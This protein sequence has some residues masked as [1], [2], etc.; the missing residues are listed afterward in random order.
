M[1]PDGKFVIFLGLVWAAAACQP[2][3]A[4]T[5]TASLPAGRAALPSFPSVTPSIVPSPTPTATPGGRLRL[6]LDFDEENGCIKS[7][8]D[9]LGSGGVEEGVYRIRLEAAN[10]MTFAPCETIVIGDLVLEV[11]MTPERLPGGNYYYGVLF[12]ITGDQ[13][14]AFVLGAYQN[15]CLYYADGQ[16]VV[17]L[18]NSTDFAATCWVRLPQEAVREGQQRFRVAAV[19]G[20]IDVYLNGVLLGVVRDRQLSGGWVGLTAATGDE[21]GLTLA[22]ERLT[23]TDPE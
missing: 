8:E 22:V 11:T 2:Q 7:Y 18:T 9:E 12:R 19:G 1:K 15:Y 6:D 17:H 4:S 13:R 5:P 3:I 21:G 16:E 20:R 23:V 10:T 14:Y